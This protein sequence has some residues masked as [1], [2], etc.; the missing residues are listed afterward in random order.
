MQVLMQRIKEVLSKAY[1]WQRLSVLL[2]ASFF[3]S[4]FLRLSNDL[5]I[6]LF[7]F[8]SAL[9]VVWLLLS[10]LKRKNSETLGKKPMRPFWVRLVATVTLVPALLFISSGIGFGIGLAMNP[11]TAEEIA[12]NEV[13]AATEKAEREAREAT[14]KAEREEQARQ[15]ELD[16]EAKELEESK[17]KTPSPTAN[18]RSDW[19]KGMEEKGWIEVQEGIWFSWAEDFSCGY[20]NCQYAFIA[21]EEVCARGVY[22]EVTIEDDGVS[23]GRD[24]EITSALIPEDGKLAQARLH[25]IDTTN[26]A[27]SWQPVSIF[28]RD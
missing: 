16:R 5:L 26:T 17:E 4:L 25:F 27:T 13:R 19:E 18:A 23:I 9:S 2:T 3:F 7:L 6:T 21:V 24:I 12:A 11:Y 20:Y 1:F 8:I 15:D 10:L 14:E 22:V 28:C